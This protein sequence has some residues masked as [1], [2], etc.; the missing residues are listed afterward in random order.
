MLFS[1]SN[2]RGV[3]AF[4]QKKLI[5][6]ANDFNI[7]QIY[8]N[9]FVFFCVAKIYIEAVKSAQAARLVASTNENNM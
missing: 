7:I 3:A 2:R 5:Y 1:M 6:R 4:I 9:L 8:L